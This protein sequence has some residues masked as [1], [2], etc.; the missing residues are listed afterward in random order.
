M[1]HREVR[2][3]IAD[4]LSRSSFKL[5]TV[6]EDAASQ[7]ACLHGVSVNDVLLVR[8]VSHETADLFLRRTS[9]D[10]R[11]SADMVLENLGW[12]LWFANLNTP[13]EFAK[14]QELLGLPDAG[15]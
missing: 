1:L 2:P 6:F 13:E 9:D 3:F 7:L 12:D 10:A 15:S 14:A 4:A 8:E 11:S 5:Y